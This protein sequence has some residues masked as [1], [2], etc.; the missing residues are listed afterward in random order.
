MQCIVIFD[1]YNFQAGLHYVSIMVFYLIKKRHI[2]CL[3]IFSWA[4][5]I[6]R[7]TGHFQ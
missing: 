3:L 1:F 4:V 5:E 6:A 2:R 7:I